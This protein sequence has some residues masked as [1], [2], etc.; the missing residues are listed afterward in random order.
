MPTLLAFRRAKSCQT[1]RENPR[2]SYN[3]VELLQRRA[4]RSRT[5]RPQPGWITQGKKNGALVTACIRV[6]KIAMQRFG[7]LAGKRSS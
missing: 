6:R 1:R 5:P 7:K 3:V 4:R 2:N